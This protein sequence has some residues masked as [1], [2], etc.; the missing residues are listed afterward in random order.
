[1]LLKQTLGPSLLCKSLQCLDI[2]SGQNSLL[3]LPESS[4]LY[5]LSSLMDLNSMRIVMRNLYKGI[6]EKKDV[7]FDRESLFPF[8]V[9][10]ISVS[11]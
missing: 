5:Q 11:L 2:N 3:Q 1:M 9:L 7:E 8:C 4:F 10:M 6:H